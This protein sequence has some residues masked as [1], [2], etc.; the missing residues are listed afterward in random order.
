MLSTIIGIITGLSGPIASVASKI[1]DLRLAKTNADSDTE[2]QKIDQQIEEAHDRQIVLVAE[3]GNRINAVVRLI[4]TIG[5]AAILLKLFLWD[6]VIGS[7]AGCTAAVPVISC[8]TFR[9]DPIDVY[10]WSVITAV[11]AFYFVYD[12]TAR[13]RK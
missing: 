4:L 9:T 3:A 2:K 6:K 5:P 10:Q 11:I 12:M 7:F 8:N 1:I 13:S